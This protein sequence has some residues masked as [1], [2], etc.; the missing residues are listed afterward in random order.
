MVSFSI[1]PMS[2][3]SSITVESTDPMLSK[4]LADQIIIE[5]EK[6]NRF[7]K[8]QT[9]GEKIAFIELRIAS[10]EEDL[11]LSEQSLKLFNEQN[12]QISTPSL[13]LEQERLQ[14]DVEVQKIFI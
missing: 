3:F 6:L 13:L 7:F 4:D 11:E 2:L 5:L 9:V 1:D 10:V 12:R 8:N 14:R